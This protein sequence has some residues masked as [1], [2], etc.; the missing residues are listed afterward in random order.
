[1]GAMIVLTPSQIGKVAYELQGTCE[2][3]DLGRILGN[4]FED[5]SLYD[6]AQ[7]SII[8]VT[9]ITEQCELC[10]WWVEASEL[11]ED[12]HRQICL[13]CATDEGI[14]TD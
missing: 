3:P 11:V 9:D 5:L 14:Q 12:G 13:D 6:L 1:M 7:E 4:E 8:A 10:G 2:W